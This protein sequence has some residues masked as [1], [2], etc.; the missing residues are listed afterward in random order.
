MTQTEKT[1]IQFTASQKALI[2]EY[3]K[4]LLGR[5]GLS[6][7]NLADAVITA[8]TK[9]LDQPINNSKGAK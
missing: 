3:R 2:V 6:K 4:Q 7:I 9:D 5:L 8:V 1:T